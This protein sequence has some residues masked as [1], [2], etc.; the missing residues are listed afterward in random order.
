MKF[1]TYMY[2]FWVNKTR[3]IILG[4]FALSLSLIQTH[5]LYKHTREQT[6]MHKHLQQMHIET[7]RR[8]E[9]VVEKEEMVDEKEEGEEETDVEEAQEEEGKEE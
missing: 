4:Y 3:S 9:E 1:C 8:E 6:F 5:E 2:K 7:N